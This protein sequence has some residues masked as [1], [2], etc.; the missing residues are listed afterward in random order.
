MPILF[1]SIAIQ[2]ACAVHCVRN[3]RN[4]MWL[5]VIIFLSI[6]GCL[7]YAFFE[8]MPGVMG[9]REVRAAKEA[10]IRKL[11]PERE[12]RAAREAVELADTVANRIALGDALVATGAD[13]EAI[14]HYENALARNPNPDRAT[15]LKLARSQLHSGNALRA[16]QLLEALPVSSSQGE[17][18]RAKLL[19]ARALEECGEVEAALA[20]YAD[21]GERL[22]GAEAQ[23][24]QAALL[25]GHGRK[26]EA[27]QLLVEAERRAKRLDRYERA[28]NADMYGWAARMLSELRAE[29]R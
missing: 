25:I 22:P 9:R 10:A 29:G 3:G 13:E 28:Q 16:R 17:N 14:R 2:I 12:V 15:Q 5:T 19:L 21:V 1:L 27:E 18:D 7:A 4:S 6:P 24:R 8:I 23:C 20:H 11:D 26:A